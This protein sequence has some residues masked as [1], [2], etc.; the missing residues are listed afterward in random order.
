MGEMIVV[1]RPRAVCLRNARTLHIRLANILHNEE[2]KILVALLLTLLLVENIALAQFWPPPIII[3]REKKDSELGISTA[4]SAKDKMIFAV[5][6]PDAHLYLNKSLK[7]TIKQPS[8]SIAVQAYASRY[9]V[10]GDG[11]LMLFDNLYLISAMDAQV[12]I[13]KINATLGNN[14]IQDIY[15]FKTNCEGGWRVYINDAAE[16]LGAMLYAIDESKV[17][18]EQVGKSIS[19][20]PLGF[21]NALIHF[22]IDSLSAFVQ[23][24]NMA[25]NTITNIF[26]N[27]IRVL[28]LVI[29]HPGDPYAQFYA[30]QY[31]L[32]LVQHESNPYIGNDVKAVLN[33]TKPLKEVKGLIPSLRPE[34]AD[35]TICQVEESAPQGI[36]GFMSTAWSIVMRAGSI[37]VFIVKNFVLINAVV[38]VSILAFGA[39]GTIKKRSIEP[40]SSSL[41][42]IYSVFKFYWSI[43]VFIYNQGLKFVQAA[44]QLGSVLI[45]LGEKIYNVA[46]TVMSIII[47]LLKAVVIYVAASI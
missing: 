26:A 18:K 35:K 9:F 19:N 14:T 3:I 1:G 46:K 45:Q 6:V 41:H 33:C 11:Q 44:T 24:L 32:A 7:I 2:A 34:D 30:A 10:Y 28:G 8:C 47:E 5:S 25:A 40:L 22:I 38:L 20:D 23:I 17:E 29:G 43:G 36:A 39:A 16:V 27:G 4:I 42:I 21:L 12:E 15:A 13:Y 31:R 37:V